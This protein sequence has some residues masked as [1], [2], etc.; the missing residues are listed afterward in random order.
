MIKKG[1]RL[2]SI[3][4]GKCP[5]CHEGEFFE[6]SFFSGKP[7]EKCSICDRKYSKEP[8]FYQGSYYVVYALGVAI[9]VAVW[10][11]IELFIGNVGF[12]GILFSVIIGLLVSAP[13]TYPLSKII[14]A[15]L[16]FH[17]L[18]EKPGEEK[19]DNEGDAS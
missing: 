5:H 16:F 17:Y 9:F 3:L 11:F 15:N 14:W 4:F 2:Y 18:E 10:V 8:G 13:F 19:M 6:G 7:K 12:N 1:V